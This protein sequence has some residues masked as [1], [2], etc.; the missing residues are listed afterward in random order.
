MKHETRYAWYRVEDGLNNMRI[1]VIEVVE[2]RHTLKQGEVVPCSTM[3]RWTG[4]TPG[5]R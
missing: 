4:K 1:E 2:Y 5:R 3:S